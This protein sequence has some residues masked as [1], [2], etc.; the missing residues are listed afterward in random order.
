MARRRVLSRG[1]A[2]EHARTAARNATLAAS[3]AVPSKL[4][5]GLAPRTRAFH[6]AANDFPAGPPAELAAVPRRPLTRSPIFERTSVFR[7]AS[8]MKVLAGFHFPLRTSA[9]A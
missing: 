8:V 4:V 2:S 7:S 1:G 3:N 9:G 6:R 5:Y